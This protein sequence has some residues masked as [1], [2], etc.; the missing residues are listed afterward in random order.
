MQNTEVT[1]AKHAVDANL[2]RLGSINHKKNIQSLN[3]LLGAEAP[4]Q[5]GGI[6][7]GGLFVGGG[8]GGGFYTGGFLT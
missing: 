1:F 5:K 6:C 8:G 2:F 3:V 4:H 7:P